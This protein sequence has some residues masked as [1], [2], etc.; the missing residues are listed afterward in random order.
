MVVEIRATLVEFYFL[1]LRK[2]NF[3][4]EEGGEQMRILCQMNWEQWKAL[5]SR[6]FWLP[7]RS[8]NEEV[9]LVNSLLKFSCILSVCILIPT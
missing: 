6:V 7:A 4:G 3:G 9:I 1:I 5:E 8:V 2:S